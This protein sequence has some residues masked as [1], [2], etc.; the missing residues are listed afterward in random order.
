LITSGFR[1]R[2][3]G[4]ASTNILSKTCG[5]ATPMVRA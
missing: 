1:G 4:I 3:L 2:Q 5:V